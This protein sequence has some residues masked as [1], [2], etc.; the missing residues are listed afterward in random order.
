MPERYARLAQRVN[1]WLTSTTARGSS[2][3]RTCG[4]GP[5]AKPASSCRASA[6]SG[7]PAPS[8][9]DLGHQALT[10]ARFVAGDPAIGAAFEAGA[11]RA[12]AP[13]TR[14]RAARRRRGRDA[15][16]DADGHPNPSALFDLKHDPGGMVDIEFA[17]Q[18]LVLATR[19][20]PGLTRNAAT[21]RC[22]T[23]PA[24]SVGTARPRAGGRRCLPR[25]PSPAARAA[26]RRRAPRADRGRAL[27]RSA[28]PCSHC[29][30][31]CSR[32]LARR[33]RVIEALPAQAA[34]AAGT[35]RLEFPIGNRELT[36]MSMADRDG[37]IWYDGKLV[38][39]ATRARTCSPTRCTTAMGVFRGVRCYATDAG[40]AIFRLADHTERLFNSAKIFG[41]KIP[42]SADELNGRAEACVRENKLTP[43]TSADRFY[44]SNAMGVAARSNPCAWRSPRAWGA[45]LGAE[46]LEKASACARPRTPTITRT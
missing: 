11:R 39:C 38:P 21:S 3:R 25:L 13:A 6:R 42:Y 18:Y 19:R 12:A 34:Q 16:A 8:S 37:W 31:T 2:T 30:G 24:S 32:R 17:V 15:P 5:T 43:A 41:M 14:A 45:Y 1:T 22:C 20:A 7:A 9:L 35:F 23:W 29:G 33:R 10:R 46:G 40:P 27:A 26:P 28:T 4:C 36:K 44:G